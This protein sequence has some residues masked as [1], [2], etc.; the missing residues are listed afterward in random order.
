[1]ADIQR[2]HL[3][4]ALIET[5]ES[6]TFSAVQFTDC[7]IEIPAGKF[8]DCRFENSDVAIFLPDWAGDDWPAPFLHTVY[9][10]GCTVRIEAPAH[11]RNVVIDGGQLWQPP[12]PV[13]YWSNVIIGDSVE[14]FEPASPST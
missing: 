10:I 2:T 1:M 4:G 6:D 14:V 12:A 11:M 7:Q 13:R 3:K 9:L 5:A 8:G